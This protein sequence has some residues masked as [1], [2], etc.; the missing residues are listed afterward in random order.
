MILE[1]FHDFGW[2]LLPGS[3]SWN[4]FVS[5]WPKWNGF[6]RIPI[7]NTPSLDHSP[8]SMSPISLKQLFIL[9]HQ[10]VWVRWEHL[11][12]RC[13]APCRLWRKTGK[14]R[15]P[16]PPTDLR[17]STRTWCSARTRS[18]S[19]P[20]PAP[21]H[22]PHHRYKRQTKTPRPQASEIKGDLQRVKVEV[23]VPHI[24]F[25][26]PTH[27]FQKWFFLP[28]YSENFPF[29]HLFPLIFEVFF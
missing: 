29:F 19:G 28:K 12:V 15:L 20:C 18:N 3:V 27:F 4:G 9:E 5:G 6:K 8:S 14:L 23:Q 1:I 13:G 22:R 25:F 16:P 10:R 21:R 24:L 26:C 2:F 7:R 11:T 17:A